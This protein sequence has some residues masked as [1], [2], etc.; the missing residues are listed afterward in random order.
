MG[1]PEDPKNNLE[2]HKKDSGSG[3]NRREIAAQYQKIASDSRISEQ[4]HPLKNCQNPGWE[5]QE[6]GRENKCMRSLWLETT[7]PNKRFDKDCS[8]GFAVAAVLGTLCNIGNA[9]Q[10]KGDNQG[11]K[12]SRKKIAGKKS[13]RFYRV[14]NRNR[15]CN[16]CVCGALSPPLHAIARAGHEILHSTG[17]HL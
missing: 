8:M 15:S 13:P 14:G 17:G 11:E 9:P 16:R 5:R 1:W 6:F 12:K 4:H 7:L 10:Q 2:T 3:K